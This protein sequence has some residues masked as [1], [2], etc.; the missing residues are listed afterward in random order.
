MVMKLRPFIGLPLAS[1]L[2]MTAGAAQAAST[3]GSFEY[4]SSTTFATG[5][6]FQGQLVAGLS[7]I[8]Y[9]PRTGTFIAQRDN[10]IGNA[11][12][13]GAGQPVAFTLAAQPNGTGGFGLTMTGI[14][15]LGPTPL[16]GL[17]SIRYDP[18]G[19]GIWLTSEAPHTVYHIDPAGNATQL[20]LDPSVNGRFASGSGNYGLEGLTFTPGGDLWVARENAL[21]GDATNIVRL[22]QIGRDGALQRQFAYQLDTVNAPNRPGATI[23]NPPSPGVGNNGVSEMLAL[24]DDR[25][26]VMERGWDGIGANANPTGV[27][28]NTIR[29]YEVDLAGAT[30]VSGLGSLDGGNPFSTVTKTLVFDSASLAGVLN[31]YDTKIDNIE[32][33]TFGPTLADGRRS[34]VM[35]SDNNNSNSQ[36]KTQFLVFGVGAV[37]EPTTWAMMIVGF[38]M[39]GAATRH[40]RKSARTAVPSLPA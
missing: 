21:A 26:L 10:W 20:V 7:G 22:S 35:V 18:T 16:N 19:N 38:G 14:D 27:S 5:T 9:N 29:V 11:G 8:D 28:H 25:F 15:N 6:R 36:R 32:G 12:P 2:L 1:F 17:E 4:L 30:N 34:L 24:S 13:G 33:M 3:I 37:P 39:V 31:T 23:A 40:R